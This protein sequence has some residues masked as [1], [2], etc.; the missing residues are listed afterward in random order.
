MILTI[1]E[2]SSIEEVQDKFT[3][4]FPGYS[5]AFYKGSHDLKKNSSLNG[6]VRFAE[7]KTQFTRIEL[8]LNSKMT[9]EKIEEL[10]KSGHGLYMKLFRLTP[11]GPQVLQPHETLARLI[12]NEVQNNEMNSDT[13]ADEEIGI[14]N[15]F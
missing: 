4:C 14:I 6:H 7:V 8:T 12:S 15:S 5:I 9:S 10:F 3:E 2:N 13:P 11:Q 1:T